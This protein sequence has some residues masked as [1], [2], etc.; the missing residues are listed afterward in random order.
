MSLQRFHFGFG[1]NLVVSQLTRSSIRAFFG[2]LLFVTIP[3]FSV[4]FGAF[5]ASEAL[6]CVGLEVVGVHGVSGLEYQLSVSSPP[7]S[8]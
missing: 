1:D 2:P 5:V 8:S 7:F 4:L 3:T 6:G